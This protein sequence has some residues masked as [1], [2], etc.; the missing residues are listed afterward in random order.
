MPMHNI[1]PGIFSIGCENDSAIF[2]FFD[3]TDAEISLASV[4]DKPPFTALFRS[5]GG[6]VNTEVCDGGIRDNSN[7]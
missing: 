5:V 6:F 7:L 2:P 3:I 1:P 4:V